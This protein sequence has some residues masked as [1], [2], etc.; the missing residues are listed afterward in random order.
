MLLRPH[1]RAAAL[2]VPVPRNG[3]EHGIADEAEHANQSLGQ[4]ERIGRGMVAVEAPV[5][6][7]RFAGTRLL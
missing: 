1:G 5:S 4:F 7:S 6:P 3:I 2:V